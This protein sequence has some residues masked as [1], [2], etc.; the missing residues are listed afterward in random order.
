MTPVFR[1]LIFGVL[2]TATP[3][4]AVL[5]QQAALRGFVIDAST[6]QALQGASVVL[7]DAS[8]RI[9]G[10]A[11][12]G[13]GYFAVNRIRPGRY[14]LRVSFV[15]FAPY[16][17]ALDLSAGGVV[18]RN[19]SLTPSETEID[20]VL[21]EAEAEAGI[22]NVS[23]GLQTVVPAQ[24]EQVP[25]PG[26][27][28]D[29][30]S[31]LQTVPGVVVQG[32]RGGQF[33][34]R[35]GA[36]DQ[37]LA[38][39]DGIPVYMPFHVLSF[40]SA[41]PDEIIDNVDLYTGGF[42]ARYGSRISSIFDVRTRNGN[43]QYLAGA[44]SLAPFLSTARI[45]GPLIRN[46]VSVIASV[47]HSLVEEV[48]PKIFDQRLPY[49]FGDQFA[50]L[51]GFLGANHS[52]S[53]VG[54]HTF[55]RGDLAGTR[56]S[57]RGDVEPVF[58]STD[59]LEA[60][61]NNALV[62]G[63]YAYLSGALPLLAE[64]SIGYSEMDNA[65]GPE[66]A[67]ERLAEMK[68]LDLAAHF[69]VFVSGREIRFGATRRTS[70]LAYELDDV[71]QGFT[72]SSVDITEWGAYT[73]LR[74]PVSG[75]ALMLEPGLHLYARP[76]RS[77]RWF[78]PRL[79]A[80]FRPRGVAGRPELNAAWGIYH[81]SLIG[82]ND[83]RDIGNLFTAWVPV[84]DDADV[85][86]SMHA[87]LGIRWR[88]LQDIGLAVEGFHKRFSNLSVPRFSA[89]PGFTTALER[90]DGWS[91]GFDARVDFDGQSFWLESV[92]DGY[93]SYALSWVEYETGRFAYHPSHDRRHHFNAV[94]R[95]TR[96][97]INVTVQFQYGSG[98]PFTESAGFDVWY[99]LT[100]EVDVRTEPGIDRIAYGEP[101]GGRQP[102]YQRLDVWIE[103]RIE[104]G[105]NVVK[106]RAGAVNVFNRD[107]LF[108]Y[109]LYTFKRV[110][111]LPLVP[112]VGVKVELR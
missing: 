12:D 107:N 62:G 109:D 96:G 58:G 91:A 3:G 40:Y 37:N 67:P 64:L 17:E 83:E 36:I 27:S 38:L 7:T 94:L 77:Q 2:L 47:R 50:K 73:E 43:K 35:G 5:A 65:I 99:L 71:F 74:L 15:G 24:I 14:E 44:V 39:L 108:Y 104:R 112:S 63:R 42:G 16:D 48:M 90:A 76:D 72:S 11:T 69:T 33:F 75:G 19:I 18:Q 1:R 110:D 59:S 81:Q 61:W 46:R 52:F 57:F 87:I 25:M 54:L 4:A 20:E 21:V 111:Q 28:G 93:A 82:L 55:D 102:A 97:P 106:L 84:P 31:Y 100:P 32:D 70:D 98:L 6:E 89:F 78:E 79:R 26:V 13:D 45:E 51:H 101:F 56:K 49:R 10:A 92:L 8:G 103:R 68:S 105:R 29:L 95:A 80:S 23:A 53:V 41:F 86:E 66:G 88:P 85:P 22:T 9:T 60:S 30:A 34:V